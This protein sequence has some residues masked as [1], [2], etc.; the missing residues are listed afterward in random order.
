[1]SEYEQLKKQY[2]EILEKQKS[3]EQKE[4]ARQATELGYLKRNLEAWTDRALTAESSLELAVK[5]NEE[6][7]KVLLHIRNEA[8]EALKTP[9]MFY[10][11]TALKAIKMEVEDAQT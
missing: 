8:I 10:L 11:V 4:N 3:A 7:K 2:D 9:T 1:M 6:L 5:E